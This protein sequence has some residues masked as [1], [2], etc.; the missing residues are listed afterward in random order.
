MKDDSRKSNFR[1]VTFE[2]TLDFY[3]SIDKAAHLLRI[4]KSEFI[5]DSIRKNLEIVNQ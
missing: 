4:T 1:K 5:R 2:V 3:E